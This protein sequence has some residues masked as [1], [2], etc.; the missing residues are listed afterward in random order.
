MKNKVFIII[1]VLFF[2]VS[3]GQTKVEKV[4]SE[5]FH[6]IPQEFIY[7]SYNSNFL[8]S[9]ETLLYKIYCL[10]K[11]TNKKSKLSKVA[12]VEV[13]AP[14]KTSIIKQKVFLNNGSG[15]G[16]IFIKPEYASGHYKLIVY[17]KWMQN[18]DLFFED[19]L[20]IINPFFNK[21]ESNKN[22]PKTYNKRKKNKKDIE[23]SIITS[24]KEV[25]KQREE[26]TLYFNNLVEGDYS[27]SIKKIDPTIFTK[28]TSSTYSFKNDNKSLIKKIK[29]TIY[30]P[31][32]RGDLIQGEVFSKYKKH[33]VANLRIGLSVI[34]KNG[35]FKFTNTN[36]D[37]TFYINLSDKKHNDK[38]FLQVLDNLI[39]S[40]SLEIKIIENRKFNTEKLTFTEIK[41]D[42]IISK[43]IDE[44]SILLQI[45]NAYSSIKEDSIIKKN[46]INFFKGYN[47]KTYKLDNYTRFENLKETMTEIVNGAWIRRKGN[48]YEFR[49]KQIN[50]NYLTELPLIIIDGFIIKNHNDL[51]EI[52]TNK[53]D[54]ISLDFNTYIFNSKI[55]EGI[56]F[57]ETFLGNYE[58]KNK[59]NIYSFN[60]LSANPNKKKFEQKYLENARKSRIPDYRLQLLWNPQLD[61]NKKEITFFTS[62]VKGEF[63]VIIDGFTKDGFPFSAKK[64]IEVK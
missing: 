58:P 38:I 56:I 53:I 61:T 42:S 28:K 32:F 57:I 17:T 13:F 26:V 40:D 5:L 46:K 4:N 55:Y 22:E 52:N 1:C 37:G 19:D 60:L 33:S 39:Y 3:F 45:E 7:T 10:N 49:I 36:K 62:D 27:L 24:N 20:A 14:N 8:L 50:K 25:Y 6:K 18:E 54:Q 23:N 41:T 30:L 48:D 2:S 59:K 47:F 43:V 51:V 16:E 63:E 9:G 12:Y 35:F 21:L 29:D 34:K 44:R 11:L 31:D 64:N 15:N